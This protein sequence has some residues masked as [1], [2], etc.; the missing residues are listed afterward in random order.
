MQTQRNN[1]YTN[2]VY[3]N[4]SMNTRSLILTDHLGNAQ[5][6]LI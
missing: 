5:P 1:V 4:V 2:A 6:T 3:A